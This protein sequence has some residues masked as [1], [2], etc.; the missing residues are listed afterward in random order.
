MNG[1]G[2]NRRKSCRAFNLLAAAG[3]AVLV[4]ACLPLAGAAQGQGGGAV[5]GEGSFWRLGVGAGW[6]Y[7]SLV[8]R[9]NEG[10]VISAVGSYTPTPRVR[11]E[12]GVRRMQCADCFR[13]LVAEGGIQLRLPLG[14]WVPFVAGGIG[15]TSDPEFVGTRGH[16]HAGLGIAREPRDRPWG[17][18]FEVRGRQLDPGDRMGEVALGVT[19]RGRE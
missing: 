13:F 5:P 9:G 2:A 16:L 11:V 1:P 8:S 17:L 18:Q 12:A 3:V 19:I 6:S 10:I 15:V 14:V 4:A 7:Y